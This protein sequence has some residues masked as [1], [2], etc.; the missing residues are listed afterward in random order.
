[1]SK[2]VTA[3][4]QYQV[5]P[6]KDQAIKCAEH[7]VRQA[8]KQGAHLILL[9]ELFA[10]PYFCQDQQEPYLEWAEPVD[11][12]SFLP[13]FQALAQEL[14]VFLPV[15]FYELAGQARFN[16]L[17]H[18]NREGQIEF[19]YR[20]THIPDGPGYQ[21]KFYFAPGDRQLRPWTTPWGAVGSAIC[22]DQWYPENARI[23]TLQ[24]AGLL[25]YPTAIGS[26]PP[27]A[28]EIDTSAMWRRAMVGH[29]VSNSVYVGAANRVG[30]EGSQTFYGHSFICDYRGEILSQA[31]CDLETVLC[32]EIDLTQAAK[33]R[34]AMGFFRDRRPALYGKL[35]SLD[36]SDG[37]GKK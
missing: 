16:S 36:G 20:K 7:W 19:I 29:A 26:E 5:P 13:R 25:L 10:G 3:V 37:I 4:L 1:M 31:D 12:H 23:L 14:S 22:W 35:L 11:G 30:R 33:F 21:E 28:N 6:Q 2:F 15:S 24:G 27:E 32:A 8:S 18:I 17:A 9:P 34:A